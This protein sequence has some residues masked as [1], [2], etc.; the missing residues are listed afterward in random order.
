MSENATP[1]ARFLVKRQHLVY[2]PLLA[3][4]R[5]TWAFQSFAYAFKVNTYW[6]ATSTVEVQQVK[7]TFEVAQRVV[8]VLHWAW[9]C[10][11]VYSLG[12]WH[13]LGFV[14]VSQGFCGLIMALAFAV[15]HNGMITYDR[16]ATPGFFELQVTTGRDVAPTLFNAWFTGGLH[17]QI[18]HHMF[19]TIPRHNLAAVSKEVQVSSQ[20]QRAQAGAVECRHGQWL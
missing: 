14:V 10:A 13:G 20:R 8:L 15:G 18:E 9:Y 4:A 17:Y 3:F 5:L 6:G 16:A 2:F 1:L 12:F 7:L 11:L 19:P